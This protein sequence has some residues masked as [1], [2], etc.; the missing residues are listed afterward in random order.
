MTHESLKT[1]ISSNA[2]KNGLILNQSAVLSEAVA[3]LLFVI[4]NLVVRSQPRLIHSMILILN[5][6]FG[7]RRLT[8]SILLLNNSILPL[9]IFLDTYTMICVP[10]NHSAMAQQKVILR[11]HFVFSCFVCY[12][13]IVIVL[14]IHL[15][16]FIA[17]HQSMQFLVSDCSQ[18]NSYNW[19]AISISVVLLLLVVN[20]YR[21]SLIRR[22]S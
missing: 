14:I 19:L 20:F 11:L 6:D 13:S 5:T 15:L 3:A 17:G 7:Y 4:G 21:Y 12:C 1:R 2:T 18:S 8:L 10:S 9:S 22:L 16:F